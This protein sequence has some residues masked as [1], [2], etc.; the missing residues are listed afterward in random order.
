MIV[1]LAART[2]VEK[3]FYEQ[4]SF[5]EINYVGTVNLIESL[6]KCKNVPKLLFASTMEVFGWQP[7]SDE[8]KNGA[9]FDKLPVF[10]SNTIPRPNAPYAVAKLACEKYIEYAHRSHGLQYINVR[11]TNS[12]GRQDNNFFVTEQIISQMLS[13][14]ICKLGYKDPYRNFLFISDLIDA[15]QTMIENFDL[16]ANKTFTLGPNNAIRIEDYAIMISDLLA[17]KGKI[18]WDTKPARPGEI[19]L[20]N[21]DEQDIKQLTGWTSTVSLVDG[22]KQTIDLLKNK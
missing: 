7:I 1:H 4:A 5:S 16:C 9:R 12:Y 3:S 2:E 19:Y 8:I 21:S 22:V 17:W 20:L 11:Q 13:G 14:S 15:W 6:F 18:V 10:D